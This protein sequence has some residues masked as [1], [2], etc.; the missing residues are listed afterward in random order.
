LLDLLIRHLVSDGEVG[1][2]V[3]TELD[4]GLAGDGGA[5]ALLHY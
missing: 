4:F 2:P 5:Y 1:L 3:K